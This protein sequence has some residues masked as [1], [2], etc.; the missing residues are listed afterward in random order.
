V[1]WYSSDSRAYQDVGRRVP[2]H[3]VRVAALELRAL[4][5]GDEPVVVGVVDRGGVDADHVRVALQEHRLHELVGL[6]VVLPLVLGEH[7]LG[8]VDERVEA[9]EDV[10]EHAPE[11]ALEVPL[12]EVVGMADPVD[13][14]LAVRHAFPLS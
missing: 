2:D 3:P 10:V 1:T 9:V 7:G 12:G 13:H 4:L 5:Y 6:P 14:E 8:R 11:A